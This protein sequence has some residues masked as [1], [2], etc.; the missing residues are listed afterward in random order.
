M[1][2]VLRLGESQGRV[3]LAEAV[4]P[5]SIAVGALEGLAGEITVVD[6]EAWVSVG[7]PA[8]EGGGRVA[9]AREHT[10]E[11]R[12]ALLLIAEVDSWESLPLGGCESLDGLEA[13][14]ALVLKERGFDSSEPVP[15]RVQVEQ[16]SADW[17][18]VDGACPIADPDGP[19]PIRE[20][21]EGSPLELVGFYVEGAAGRFT[22]HGRAS[23]LH[24]LRVG[25]SGRVVQTG[26]LDQLTFDG[27]ARVLIPQR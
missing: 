3:R 16:G 10:D 8:A 17:H 2:E 7:R 6:G 25:A 21:V 1:R 26:H 9:V 23:H 14:I 15:V 11:D 5:T 12:A 4:R 20:S 24:M 13:R 22:H 27:A 18:V 19:A